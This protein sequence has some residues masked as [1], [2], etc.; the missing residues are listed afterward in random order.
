V[1]SKE[2]GLLPRQWE[3]L[4][5]Q[6]GGAS[7]ALRRIIDEARKAGREKDQ[8]RAAQESAYRFMSAAAGDLPGY[9]EA[10][11]ALFAGDAERF[12]A[13]VADWPADVRDHASELAQRA[14]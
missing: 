2:V 3:W 14:M 1:V 9:E 10:L 7:A 13:C 4:H 6:P 11:R 5:V 8:V 12:A